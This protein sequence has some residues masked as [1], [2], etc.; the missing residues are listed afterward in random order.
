MSEQATL[1]NQKLISSDLVSM[2]KENVWN[3]SIV[4][5]TGPCLLPFGTTQKNRKNV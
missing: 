3:M 1:A 4:N 2:K 5:Q